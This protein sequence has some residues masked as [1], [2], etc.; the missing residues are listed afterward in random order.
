MKIDIEDRWGGRL[1]G[2]GAQ[3]IGDSKIHLRHYN[4]SGQVVEG[5]TNQRHS[6]SRVV[7]GLAFLGLHVLNVRWSEGVEREPRKY[8]DNLEADRSCASLKQ[9]SLGGSGVVYHFASPSPHLTFNPYYSYV[10]LFSHYKTIFS[11]DIVP[12]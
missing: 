12:F 2:R 8:P 4:Q 11:T 7:N 10:I 1:L 5:K 6:V 3:R 9:P